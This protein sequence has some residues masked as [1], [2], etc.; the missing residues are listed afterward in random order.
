MEAYSWLE[1]AWALIVDM[2]VEHALGV[3]LES[4][5]ACS[6]DYLTLEEEHPCIGLFL[7]YDITSELYMCTFGVQCSTCVRLHVILVGC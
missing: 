1:D 3:E 6:E 5:E 7:L 4:M 2:Y